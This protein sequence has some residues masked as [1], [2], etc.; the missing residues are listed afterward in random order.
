ML[1]RRFAVA[2]A[3]AAAAPEC[4]GLPTCS[5][6]QLSS[7]G[8]AQA[9]WPREGCCLLACWG[10]GARGPQHPGGACSGEA[11]L[12]RAGWLQKK[13]PVGRL[14]ALGGH[15]GANAPA[16]G[17]LGIAE[18]LRYF[19]AA[20]LGGGAAAAPHNLVAISVGQLQCTL[21][22]FVGVA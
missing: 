22:N 15:G 13:P 6:H 5:E 3:A 10:C 21:C 16:G 8:E 1:A 11:E 14:Q 4:T 18:Q 20:G 19:G 12:A 7:A 17:S 2:T 9:G